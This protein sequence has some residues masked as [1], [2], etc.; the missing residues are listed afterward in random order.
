MST[1]E[2]IKDC[3][4]ELI[5]CI[6]DTEKWKVKA[7]QELITLDAKYKDCM[8]ELKF[9]KLE[10]AAGAGLSTLIL[11]VLLKIMLGA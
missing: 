1:E 7:T 3:P 2:E 10:V 4:K 5:G 6:G 9:I 8:R 11:G